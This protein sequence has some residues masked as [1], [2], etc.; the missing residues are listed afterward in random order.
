MLNK[1]D[2]LEPAQAEGLREANRHRGKGPI[3]ISAVTGE[4]LDDLLARLQFCFAH[5]Q[6]VLELDLDPSDGAALAWAHA[7]GRVAARRDDDT[8][9]NL[10]VFVDRHDLDQFLHHFGERA[11]LRTGAE[12]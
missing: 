7:H 1:I 6:V 9:L 4:G 5:T 3:A 8:H 10:T 2:L 12:V 11:R